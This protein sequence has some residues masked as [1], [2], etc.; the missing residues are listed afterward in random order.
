MVRRQLPVGVI[1]I[2]WIQPGRLIS[3]IVNVEPALMTTEGETF[4]PWPKSRAA[5][6]PVPSRAMP[7]LPFSP[8]KFSGLIERVLALDV[9]Y[10]LARLPSIPLTG[11]AAA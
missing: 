8:V 9:R 1:Q 6:L 5:P 11:E 7:A 4:Q 10:K 2:C 3:P